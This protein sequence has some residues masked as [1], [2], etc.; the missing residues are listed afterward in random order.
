MNIPDRDTKVEMLNVIA[1]KITPNSSEYNEIVFKKSDGNVLATM[2]FDLVNIDGTA[3]ASPFLSFTIN[4]SKFL[5]GVASATGRAELF[6]ILDKDKN[7][8]VLSGTVGTTADISA[9]I[10]FN[11]VDWVK[12]NSIELAS[13]NIRLENVCLQK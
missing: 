5:E 13:V 4:G 2:R 7:Y 10:K 11:R 3:G 9:D 6:S 8:D 12:K 1:N